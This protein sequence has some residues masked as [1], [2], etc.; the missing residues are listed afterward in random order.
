MHPFNVKISILIRSGFQRS[1]GTFETAP[2]GQ[3]Y[4][5]HFQDYVDSIGE[6]IYAKNANSAKSKSRKSSTTNQAEKRRTSSI[7]NELS[8]LANQLNVTNDIVNDEPEPEDQADQ[9]QSSETADDDAKTDD[10]TEAS[11]KSDLVVD[12]VNCS[13]TNENIEIDSSSDPS[14]ASEFV[15]LK[16]TTTAL[17]SYLEQFQMENIKSN[18][19]SETFDATEELLKMLDKENTES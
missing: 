18:E 13:M 19:S 6:N 16:K 8:S 9:A 10:V 15:H 1:D 3:L 14:S 12:D 5:D 7:S 4:I 2:S 17:Q 11:S